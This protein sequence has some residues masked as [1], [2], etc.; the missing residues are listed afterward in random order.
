MEHNWGI[1]RKHNIYNFDY[2]NRKEPINS[3]I[4]VMQERLIKGVTDI[5]DNQHVCYRERRPTNSVEAAKYIGALFKVCDDNAI[6]INKKDILE[7]STNM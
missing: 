7:R 4:T 5:L 2:V 6:T 1:L 3:P